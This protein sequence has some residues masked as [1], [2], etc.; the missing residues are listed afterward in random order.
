MVIIE[1]TNFGLGYFDP[2]L[3]GIVEVKDIVLKLYPF[4]V[5][6]YVFYV[7]G[8]HIVKDTVVSV[9]GGLEELNNS[10]TVRV[11]LTERPV[12]TWTSS[13]TCVCDSA[14]PVKV[15]VEITNMLYTELNCNLRLDL[16]ILTQGSRLTSL[17]YYGD[18]SV[19]GNYNKLPR[20][21]EKKFIRKLVIN[22]VPAGATYTYLAYSG[23]NSLILLDNYTAM[24]Y[25]KNI[26]KG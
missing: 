3:N 21:V 17:D 20:E 7:Y 25:E 16:S 5:K 9:V 1:N 24:P 12:N 26:T 2:V 22:P 8:S 13:D 14:V 10:K 11:S 19:S 4:E 6:R 15:Y 23:G 18:L